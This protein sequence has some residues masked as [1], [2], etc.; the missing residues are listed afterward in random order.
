M[1]RLTTAHGDV[2]TA[3]GVARHTPIYDGQ[4]N[5]ST[6]ETWTSIRHRHIRSTLSTTAT[7]REGVSEAAMWLVLVLTLG[8]IQ[9]RTR[10]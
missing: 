9:E 7:D 6:K 2:E 8:L 5:H 1:D 4:S 10:R 3:T